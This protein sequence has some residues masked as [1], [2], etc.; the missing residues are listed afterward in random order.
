MVGL[1]NVIGALITVPVVGALLSQA[2]VI[3][4]QRRH[5]GR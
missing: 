4:S 1:L 2:A 5:L 3:Y